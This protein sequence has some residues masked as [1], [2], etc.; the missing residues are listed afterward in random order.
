MVR[1]SAIDFSAV[2][3]IDYTDMSFLC[4]HGSVRRNKGMWEST[5]IDVVIHEMIRKC[6]LCFTYTPVL[7]ISLV[8]TSE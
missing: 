7:T 8:S 1:E 5:E 6:Y 3:G 2:C 4:Y